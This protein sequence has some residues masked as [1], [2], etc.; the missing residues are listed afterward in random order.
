ME[1]NIIAGQFLFIA[2]N[3]ISFNIVCCFNINGNIRKTMI[4]FLMFRIAIKA[5][6]SVLSYFFLNL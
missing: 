4:H 3:L 1:E 5:D 2:V 6:L